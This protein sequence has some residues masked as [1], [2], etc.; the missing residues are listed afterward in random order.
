MI[1]FK[2]KIGGFAWVHNGEDWEQAE[3]L[4][5]RVEFGQPYYRITSDTWD[6]KIISETFLYEH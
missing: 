5:K 3:I 2:Y 6:S 1:S 4:Q